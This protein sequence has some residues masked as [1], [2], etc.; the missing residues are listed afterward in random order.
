M[1]KLD[2]N[3]LTGRARRM[4]VLLTRSRVS[5]SGQRGG[6]GSGL[7]PLIARTVSS[8]FILQTERRPGRGK[9]TKHCRLTGD[10]GWWGAGEENTTT[11][12]QLTD[13]DT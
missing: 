9:R 5:E 1:D 2:L 3:F 11:Q 4:P 8:N 12:K 10:W 6:S 7:S 13:R